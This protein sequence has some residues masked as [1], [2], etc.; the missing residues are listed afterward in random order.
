MEPKDF[1]LIV[2]AVLG[3]IGTA[4]GAVATYR[5]AKTEGQSSAAE[6]WQDIATDHKERLEKV[7]RRVNAAAVR[8]RIRDDYIFILRNHISDGKPPPPPPWPPELLHRD[9]DE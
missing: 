9:D 3:A 5:R 2:S 4:Y 7:E 6:Q 8:E 1:L